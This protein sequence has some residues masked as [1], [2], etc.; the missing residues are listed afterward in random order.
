MNALKIAVMHPNCRLKRL[1]I[2]PAPSFLEGGHSRSSLLAPDI[3]MIGRKIREY[4]LAK[5][6]KLKELAPLIGI[7]QGSLSDIE[8]EKTKR[9]ADTVVTIV[10]MTGVNPWW[11]LADQGGMFDRGATDEFDPIISK[12]LDLL[13][14]LDEASK[15]D[16][17][18]YVEDKNLLA[19]LRNQH[20]QRV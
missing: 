5:G 19:K 16:V 2:K 14:Q 20:K 18:K 12:I 4:R 17:L 1:P 6:L 15:K 10:R 8:N 7:S 3:D 9:S 11:L 13:G